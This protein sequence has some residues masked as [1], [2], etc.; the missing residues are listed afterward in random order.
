MELELGFPSMKKE[1]QI[2]GS[3]SELNPMKLKIASHSAVFSEF[4]IRKQ[5]LEEL[6]KTAAV[7]ILFYPRWVLIKLRDELKWYIEVR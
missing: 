4:S 6:P 1:T 3:L 5:F 2:K 7:F